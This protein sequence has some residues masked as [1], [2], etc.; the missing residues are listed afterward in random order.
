MVNS[1]FAISHE[2]ESQGRKV[3]TVDTKKATYQGKPYQSL[4]NFQKRKFE[5]LVVLTNAKDRPKVIYQ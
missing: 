3:L 1:N 5:N 4:S 2:S